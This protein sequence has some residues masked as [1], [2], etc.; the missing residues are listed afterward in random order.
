M[1]LGITRPEKR[2]FSPD[3]MQ[4]GAEK[5]RLKGFSTNRYQTCHGK[6]RDS[7]LVKNLKTRF[8]FFVKTSE[9][10]LACAAR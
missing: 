9:F 5:T 6:S 2:L 10:A 8:Q 1:E 4:A 3:D 7:C